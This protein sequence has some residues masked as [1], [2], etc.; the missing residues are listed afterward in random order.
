MSEAGA[1]VNVGCESC[2][3]P[4]S[5]HIAQAGKGPIKRKVSAEDCTQCHHPPHTNTFVYEDRL[6]RVLGPGHQAAP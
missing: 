3:G 6:Q 1:R 2:H 5:L 4:G